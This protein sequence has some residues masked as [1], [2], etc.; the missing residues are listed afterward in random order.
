MGGK[1]LSLSVVIHPEGQKNISWIIRSSPFFF[2]YLHIFQ[3]A[4]YSWLKHEHD[5]ALLGRNIV[6]VL[7]Q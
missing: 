1:I 5:V 2:F 4:A 6:V 7:Q 3:V